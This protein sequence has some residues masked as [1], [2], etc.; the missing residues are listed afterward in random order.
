MAVGR[1]VAQAKSISMPAAFANVDVNQAASMAGIQLEML[2]HLADLCINSAHPLALPG[3]PS[4]G[5]NNG[6]QTA[7]AIL[8]L[9][10]LIGNLGQDGGVFLSPLAPLTDQ[11]HRPASMKEITDFLATLKSG[12]VK[13]L[14]VHGVNPLFELPKSLGMK[15]ALATVPQVIS[16]ATFPDETALESDYVFPDHHV[17]ESWGY[18]KVAT[19]TQFP[20]L[21]GAQPVVVPFFQY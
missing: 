15:D 2:Q 17:L 8:A 18:Q 3:G 12:K 6:L 13:V 9:N 10:A 4:L 16:F 19:G 7:E 21:S 20:V 5:R 14:F 11:Y 1:L